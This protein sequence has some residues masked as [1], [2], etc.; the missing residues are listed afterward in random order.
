MLK[1]HHHENLIFKMLTGKK[2]LK[3]FMYRDFKTHKKLLLVLKRWLKKKVSANLK[4]G[5]LKQIS[6]MLIS[7]HF[8]ENVKLI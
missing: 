8:G 2:L 5:S 3:H 4:N 6:R 1:I 7:S